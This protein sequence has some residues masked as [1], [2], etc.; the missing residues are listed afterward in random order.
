MVAA[1]NLYRH[2][3]LSGQLIFSVPR[4]D[5]VDRAEKDVDRLRP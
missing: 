3:S 2:E 4:T 1:V 5:A